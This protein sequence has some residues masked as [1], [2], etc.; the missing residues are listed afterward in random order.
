M[1][2]VSSYL[3]RIAFNAEVGESVAGDWSDSVAWMFTSAANER[4]AEN[5]KSCTYEVKR[6]STHPNL[7][8]SSEKRSPLQDSCLLQMTS[9]SHS[10]KQSQSSG[11]SESLLKKSI[12]VGGILYQLE[13]PIELCTA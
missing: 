12:S 1:Q 6:Q 5:L 4:N 9:C 7:K 11:H 10:L 3:L 13:I 2:K 8:S